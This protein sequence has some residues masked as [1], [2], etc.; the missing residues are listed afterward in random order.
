MASTS[1]QNIEDTGI[2]R[3]KVIAVGPFFYKTEL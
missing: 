2:N 1:Q 3:W